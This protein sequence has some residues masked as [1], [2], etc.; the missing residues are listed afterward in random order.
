MILLDLEVVYEV[1]W[2]V[3]WFDDKFYYEVIVNFVYEWVNMCL[4]GKGYFDS[5][6]VKVGV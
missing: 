4:I 5:W 6:V 1:W 3:G 2:L